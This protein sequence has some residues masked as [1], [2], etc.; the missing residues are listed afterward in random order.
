MKRTICV[1]VTICVQD[2]YAI[3][4]ASRAATPARYLAP[5]G[6]EF[7]RTVTPAQS[8]PIVAQDNR[9]TKGDRDSKQALYTLLGQDLDIYVEAHADS[10][11]QAR[12][13]W[14]ECSQ[15]EWTRGADGMHRTSP[16]AIGVLKALLQ[17]SPRGLASYSTSYVQDLLPR[18]LRRLLT[19]LAGQGSYDV[20]GRAHRTKPFLNIA[21]STKLSLYASLQ[22]RMSEHRSVLSEREKALNE[23]RESLVREGGAVVGGAPK[24]GGEPKEF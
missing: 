21:Y 24:P 6:R 14:S 8:L 17:S 20:S 10:Y 3:P 23:A 15:E 9:K 5:A 13:K 2:E 19:R 7:E 22:N 12:K 11:E 16:R 4:F 18:S 1:F